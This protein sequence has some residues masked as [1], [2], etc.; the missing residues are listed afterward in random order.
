[1]H[2]ITHALSLKI[3]D[4]YALCDSTYCVQNTE[5]T[6]RDKIPHDIF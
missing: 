5:N 3:V 2:S 6:T 4:I 1:M